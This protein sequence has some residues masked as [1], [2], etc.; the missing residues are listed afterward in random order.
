MEKKIKATYFN[1]D[2]KENRLYS[3]HLFVYLLKLRTGFDHRNP[4]TELNA[5][6]RYAIAALQCEEYIQ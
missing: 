2:D 1:H 6:T 4:H 5:L 3:L